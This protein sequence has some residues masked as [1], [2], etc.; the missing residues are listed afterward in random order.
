MMAFRL[1]TGLRQT[2]VASSSSASFELAPCQ[3]IG[4]RVLRSAG[5]AETGP[6]SQEKRSLWNIG[7]SC[8]LNIDYASTANAPIAPTLRVC[9]MSFMSFFGSCSSAAK[10]QSSI[11]CSRFHL[12]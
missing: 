12:A 8:Q 3:F 1:T 7:R 11:Q 9:A 6:V 10:A 2:R 4:L 5:L